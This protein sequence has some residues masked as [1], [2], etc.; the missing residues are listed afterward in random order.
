MKATFQ[1][2][3]ELYREVKAETARQGRTMREVTI[4]LFD[5][6]L[7]EG[8][9]RKTATAAVDWR[10]FRSPLADYVSKDVTDHSMEGIR[11]SIR[12]NWNESD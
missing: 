1:I 6:W 9:G 11:A 12:K 3:D 10:H 5:Q 7:R 8:K 2:P 4:N